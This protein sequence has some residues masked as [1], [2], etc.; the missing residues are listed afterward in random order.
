[1]GD[2]RAGF[3]DGREA[4]V[5]FGGGAEG[6]RPIASLL[7][8]SMISTNSSSPM[9]ETLRWRLPVASAVTPWFIN[10]NGLSSHWR[11][12]HVSKTTKRMLLSM[13]TMSPK[14]IR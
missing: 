7:I 3:A 10:A 1:M 14:V 8:W 6:L 11:M 4:L 9:G 5:L 2:V 12:S 13:I